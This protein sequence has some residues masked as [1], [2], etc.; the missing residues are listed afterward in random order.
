MITYDDGYRELP[1]AGNAAYVPQRGVAHHAAWAQRMARNGA[2][3]VAAA[4]GPVIISG[5]SALGI[6]SSLVLGAPRGRALLPR[7]Y[8]ALRAA[9][10]AQTYGSPSKVEVCAGNTAWPY[11]APQPTD[12]CVTVDVIESSPT[13]HGALLEKVPVG[14]DRVVYV[15]FR[16]QY[17][18]LFYWCVFAEVYHE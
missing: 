3:L 11:A 17:V 14:D 2:Y 1:A 18:Q 15:C 16:L 9:F 13:E 6:T 10:M 8:N 7:P 4:R 12:V 5:Y